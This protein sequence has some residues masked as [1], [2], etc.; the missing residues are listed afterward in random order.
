MFYKILSH[1]AAWNEEAN[2]HLVASVPVNWLLLM[3]GT[4]LSL[5]GFPFF[6]DSLKAPMTPQTVTIEAVLD[7]KTPE[8][9]TLSGEFR[10]DLTLQIGVKD[11]STGKMFRID[12]TYVPLVNPDSG[13]AVYVSVEAKELDSLPARAQISGVIESLPYEVK[14]ELSK[15]TPITDV[16][17]S[18][19]LMIE[20]DRHPSVYTAGLIGFMIT[21]LTAI[22]GIVIST[23]AVK[24]NTIFVHVPDRH[25][26]ARGLTSDATAEGV[27]V[28]GT[29]TFSQQSFTQRFL[30][31]RSF[32]SIDDAGRLIFEANIDAS[33]VTRLG[34]MIEEKKGHWTL[35]IPQ[36]ELKMLEA[37]VLFIAGASVPSIKIKG[38]NGDT[39]LSF[40]S[41]E[42]RQAF[43]ARLVAQSPATHIR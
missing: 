37:G 22:Y 2:H 40:R 1:I 17:L 19:Q 14:R 33:E 25:L 11:I 36:D 18:T 12:G 42:E 28:T 8:W 13:K 43:F 35:V 21:L 20:K 15:R 26:L 29:F 34:K 23:L 32:W 10:K 41:T 3:I 5:I 24:G 38:K 39:I 31:V 4:I 6:I 27:T 9:I 30:G 16:D 7:R